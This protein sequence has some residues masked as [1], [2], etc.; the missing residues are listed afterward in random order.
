MYN[1]QPSGHCWPVAFGP[2][3]GPLHL[4]RSKLARWPLLANETQMMPLRSASMPF[5][6]YAIGPVDVLNGGSYTSVNIVEGGFGPGTSLTML[7]GTKSF[8]RGVPYVF[9]IQIEP[10]TGLI[11]T[12]YAWPSIRQS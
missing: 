11:A 2:F 3:S 6:L 9:A 7:P 10:S 12:P 4:R 5:G 1:V 8:F